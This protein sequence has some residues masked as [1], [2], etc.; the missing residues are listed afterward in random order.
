[1][2][3]K[4]EKSLGYFHEL[5]ESI[6]SNKVAISVHNCETCKYAMFYTENK[7]MC[8]RRFIYYHVYWYDSC[9]KWEKRIPHGSMSM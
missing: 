1:M 9:G 6:K 7:A 3:R 5:I 4:K 2:S 8:K